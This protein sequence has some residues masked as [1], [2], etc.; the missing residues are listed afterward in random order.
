MPFDLNP[1]FIIVIGCKDDEN[2][3]S[4]GPFPCRGSHTIRRALSCVQNH[5]RDCFVLVSFQAITQSTPF[6]NLNLRQ[7]INLRSPLILNER[8]HFVPKPNL[9]VSKHQMHMMWITCEKQCLFVLCIFAYFGACIIYSSFTLHKAY[10]KF[11]TKSLYVLFQIH[12]N[13]FNRKCFMYSD[14]V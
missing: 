6:S 8:L 5:F 12:T 14:S 13:I 2:V 11:S 4:K 9:F 1:R 7:A 10:C 3:S